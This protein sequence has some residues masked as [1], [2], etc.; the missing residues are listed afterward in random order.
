MMLLLTGAGA[1]LAFKIK[2]ALD[3]CG[4]SQSRPYLLRGLKNTFSVFTVDSRIL[5]GK[6]VNPEPCTEHLR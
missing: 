3:G 5:R 6:A 2:R 4:V 1:S